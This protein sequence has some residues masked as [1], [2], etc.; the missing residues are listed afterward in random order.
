VAFGKLP[1]QGHEMWIVLAVSVVADQH[2]QQDL[3]IARIEGGNR[4]QG[5]REIA[6]VV[7]AQYILSQ[8]L[9]PAVVVTQQ[10]TGMLGK[11]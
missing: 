6:A 5:T 11:G 4:V 7:Q 3:Q 9:G 10:Q 8:T 1:S 2:L